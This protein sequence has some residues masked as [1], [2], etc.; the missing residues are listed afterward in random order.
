[1]PADETSYVVALD[2]II[3]VLAKTAKRDSANNSL[4]EPV[5]LRPPLPRPPISSTLAGFQ[6]HF[7]ADLASEI[8]WDAQHSAGAFQSH[9]P[10]DDAIKN[11]VIIA[12]ADSQIPSDRSCHQDLA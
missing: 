1:M 4:L 3:Q 8:A 7:A 5:P 6:A 2:D 10:T 12:L 11:I 9:I